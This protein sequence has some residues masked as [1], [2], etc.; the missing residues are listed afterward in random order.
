MAEAVKSTARRSLTP[1]ARV[2][3]SSGGDVDL[4]KASS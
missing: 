1:T 3:K 4:A 2:A